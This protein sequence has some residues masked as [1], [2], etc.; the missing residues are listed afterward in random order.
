MG[1]TDEK[2]GKL[3]KAKQ[4]SNITKNTDIFKVPSISSFNIDSYPWCWLNLR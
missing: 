4:V 2:V 3:A 1:G